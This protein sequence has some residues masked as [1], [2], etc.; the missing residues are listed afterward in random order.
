MLAM[1]LHFLKSHEA[2]CIP[3]HTGLHCLHCYETYRIAF[4][5]TTKAESF[6]FRKAERI[7]LD[8]YGIV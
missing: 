2:F 1:F 7:G 8:R 3:Q 5:I 6:S 4:H